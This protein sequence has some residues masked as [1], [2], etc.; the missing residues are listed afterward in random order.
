[1]ASLT[2]VHPVKLYAVPLVVAVQGGLHVLWPPGA[3]EGRGDVP[4]HAGLAQEQLVQRAASVVPGAVQALGLR[5]LKPEASGKWNYR[6]TLHDHDSL[7]ARGGDDVV[8]LLPVHV[9]PVLPHADKNVSAAA[10]AL[11]QAPLGAAGA[12][13]GL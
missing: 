1:M 6:V 11:G 3:G 2:A 4:A 12:P 5:L 8:A 9:R 7:G 10:P 13:G